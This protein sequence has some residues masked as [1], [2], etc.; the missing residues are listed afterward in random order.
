MATTEEIIASLKSG[1]LDSGN[2]K[3]LAASAAR[4]S[5]AGLKGVRVHTRGIPVPDGIRISGMADG[6]TLRKILAELLEK[7]PHLGGIA[8]FPY[9]IP[10]P[11]IYRVDFN[12][13]H[14]GPVAGGGFGH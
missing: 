4:L 12:L 2:L 1:S 10:W 6:G 14:G 3:A 8:I 11:E 5:A 13:G 9:G 7:T